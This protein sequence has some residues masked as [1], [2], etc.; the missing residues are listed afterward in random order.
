MAAIAV[1]GGHHNQRRG[2]IISLSMVYIYK[3]QSDREIGA[4][5][6]KYWGG[7]VIRSMRSGRNSGQWRTSQP[8]T[9]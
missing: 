5:E 7:H 9:W 1:S 8:K 2:N 6:F 4:R 3:L